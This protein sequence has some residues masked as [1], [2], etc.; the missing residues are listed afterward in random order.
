M[1]KEAWG[2]ARGRL[3]G[4][5]GQLFIESGKTSDC[6]GPKGTERAIMEPT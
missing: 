5:G 4:C 6:G 3:Q 2:R 1:G